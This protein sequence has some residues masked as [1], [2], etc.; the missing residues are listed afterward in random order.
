MKVGS[1][2]TYEWLENL[3]VSQTTEKTEAFTER[4]YVIKRMN[5]LERVGKY[6]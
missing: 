5:E 2:T 3:K 4:E 6:L 1:D